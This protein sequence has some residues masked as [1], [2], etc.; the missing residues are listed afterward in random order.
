MMQT[1][2]QYGMNTMDSCLKDLTHRGLI[3]LDVAMSKVK[4][5]EE[6]KQL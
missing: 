4:N 3:T 6:F 1:G 2:L 5:R